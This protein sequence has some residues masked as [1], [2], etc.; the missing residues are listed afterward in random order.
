MRRVLTMLGL[1]QEFDPIRARPAVPNDVRPIV[2]KLTLADIFTP[3][4]PRAGRKSLIGRRRE[5][6]RIVEALTDERAHV[7]LYS[8]RG[9]GKTSLSNSV[10]E[11]LRSREIAVARTTC[12]AGSGFDD[13]MASLTRDLPTS[14]L[15]VPALE[16]TGPGCEAALPA[17]RLG[18][19]DVA[20]LPSRLTCRNLVCVI[21]EFDRV[22]DAS[23]RLMLADTIKQISDRG[24]RLLFMVIGVSDS[25]DQLIG[26]HMSIRRNVVTVLLPLM[27]DNE[28]RQLVLEGAREARYE[29]SP[30]LVEAI[31]V[32]S[33]GM[34]YI[35][36]LLGLR[37]AQ[38]ALARG[39]DRANEVDLRR[40]AERL[41][42]EAEPR[43]ITLYS[44]LTEDD[45]DMAGALRAVSTAEQDCF[46][47]LQASRGEAEIAVG[48]R[49]I[50]RDCWDRLVKAAV[51]QPTD[52]TTTKA[53]FKVTICDR[54]LITYVMLLTILKSGF[55]AESDAS[56]QS[57]RMIAENALPVSNGAR[58][59]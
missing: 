15:S 48:N 23:V 45:D 3:T 5:L 13:I 43:V 50:P 52:P 32:L 4:R 37:V 8:E 2:P 12:N 30:P 10:I 20:A 6:A 51:L 19:S 40:A 58:T 53:A 35:A 54:D 18:P 38:A 31:T 26:S 41:V 46:G 28:M 9:R 57:R 29:F 17:G 27:P 47:F 33:R 16:R 11:I 44:A 36:Q 39:T 34:P 14:L 24:A 21:D 49:L 22:E 55:R 25:L 56:A 59:F 7:V 1:R 42:D